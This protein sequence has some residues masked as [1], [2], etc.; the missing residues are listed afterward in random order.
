MHIDANDLAY[1]L[2]R[3]SRQPKLNNHEVAQ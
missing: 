2:L 1:V 3:N